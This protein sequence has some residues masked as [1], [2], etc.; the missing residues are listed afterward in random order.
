MVDRTWTLD[1]PTRW[2]SGSSVALCICMSSV[3]I[4][5]PSSDYDVNVYGL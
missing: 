3:Y 4:V 5:C 1:K 2:I